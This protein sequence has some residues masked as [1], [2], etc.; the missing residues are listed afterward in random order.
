MEH[1][2]HVDAK[3]K[4]HGIHFH[5]GAIP[6]DL[7]SQCLAA[8]VTK[9]D[10]GAHSLFLGQVR[11]DLH[12]ER[13]VSSI[14]Y[15]AMEELAEKNVREFKEQLFGR[16]RLSCIHVYHSLGLVASGEISLMI[17]VSSP[18]RKEAI[19]ACNELLEFIKKEVPIW[20]KELFDD[21]SHQWKT[22]T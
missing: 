14:E 2:K 22:N 20:G 6:P 9:K 10:I 16:F 1:L 4:N 21:G 19:E 15:S 3:G 8:H 18:H 5:Q 7:V 13:Q 11:A 12:N 17:F